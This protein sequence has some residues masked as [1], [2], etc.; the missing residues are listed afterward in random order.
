MENCVFCKIIKKEIPSQVTFENDLIMAII[1]LDQ[2]SNGHTLAISKQHFE[3]VFDVDDIVL[4]ELISVSK[5]LSKQL[6]SDV[7]ATGVN[8]LNAS[9][10]D[11]QQSVNHLHFHIVPR[12][13]SDGLDM[14]IKQSL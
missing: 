11:A 9:G 7:G 5:K 2:V 6:L 4:R 14:W 1:P 13:P 8:I 12:F 3:N 10:K